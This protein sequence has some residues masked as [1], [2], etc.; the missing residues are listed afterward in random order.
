MPH[1]NARSTTWS[2]AT[3]QQPHLPCPSC[4]MQGAE[5]HG[6][7]RTDTG[8]HAQ[9]QGLQSPG[10]WQLLL[11]FLSAIAHVGFSWSCPSS[12]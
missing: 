7:M 5:P 4:C 12:P 10:L 9:S 2:E 11:S 3:A 1:A 6:D 8:T